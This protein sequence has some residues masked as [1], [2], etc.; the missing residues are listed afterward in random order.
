M[1]QRLDREKH[2]IGNQEQL[3]RSEVGLTLPLVIGGRQRA[4]VVDETTEAANEAAID[5]TESLPELTEQAAQR[6]IP[7]PNRMLATRR[8]ERRVDRDRAVGADPR[9]RDNRHGHP[10]WM[11]FSPA[12][13]C[14]RITASD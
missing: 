11:A 10:L 14:R 6:Q 12:R 7:R 4:G 13:S 9:L 2:G 5:A 8:A 3:E 1:C